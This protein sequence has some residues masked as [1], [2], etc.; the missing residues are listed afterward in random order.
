M[1]SSCTVF[2]QVDQCQCLIEIKTLQTTL[3][4]SHFKRDVH[5]IKVLKLTCSTV[6]GL[7]W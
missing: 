6:L 1:D 7:P 4:P 2:I 3:L 5:F